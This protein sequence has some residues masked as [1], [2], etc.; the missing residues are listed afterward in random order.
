MEQSNSTNQRLIAEFDKNSA[1]KV[2]VTLQEWRC[3][4]YFDLRI[5]YQDD[6]GAWL[7]TKKGITVNVELLGELRSA[8]DKA[9]AAAE[10]GEA[11]EPGVPTDGEGDGE[12]PF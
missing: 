6:K 11:E 5:F 8:I 1:E 9:I 2:R 4:T 10:L 3:Q 12:L 7:P